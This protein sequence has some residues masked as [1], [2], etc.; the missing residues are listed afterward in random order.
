MSSTPNHA[1]TA[2]NACA[3]PAVDPK[4][5]KLID[6]FL[7]FKAVNKNRS[8]RTIEVYRLAL[9]R[10]VTFLA[11]REVTSA[12]GDELVVF[13]GAWLFRNFKLEPAARKVYVSATREF[14]RWLK[15]RK[16]IEAD[17][18]E[19]IPVPQLGRR[20]PD[21][22]S[23][24][25]AE[26]LMWAPDFNTFEG[27][28]DGAMMALLVGCGFRVSGL[29]GLNE[30]DILVHQVDGKPRM[31]LRVKEKGNKTRQ[32]PVPAE[33]D[34][35]LRMYLEHPDLKGIDRAIAQGNHPDR[36]LFVST[37]NRLVPVHEYRGE[38][39]RL[40]RRSI[41]NI[42]AK[43]GKQAGIPDRELHPHAMRHLFGTELAEA[44]VDI[45]QR[46]Q[47]MGHADPKSTAIY[48]HLA[49]TKATKA[50]D[51]GNPLSK[52]RSPVSDLLKRLAAGNSSPARP[53][54]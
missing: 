3:S 46:Q 5:L 39:R 14:Y 29:V 33:A 41:N 34:L 52:I 30:S 43:Y 11:G 22:M 1:P 31:A 37:A 27:V 44:N 47:L 18:A 15:R 36:V 23:L 26:K 7:T 42:L 25:T 38:N 50:I 54:S 28:R 48:E 16:H 6:D 53:T 45:L 13:T 17:L 32:V 40:T 4:S 35:L 21:V 24:A 49:F 2:G 9:A 51:Q 12:T 19:Q 10:L 8:A 20:L